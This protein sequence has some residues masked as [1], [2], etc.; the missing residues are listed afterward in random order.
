MSAGA[1][2]AVVDLAPLLLIADDAAFVRESYLRVLGR[3]C[4]IGGFVHY[5][6]LLRTRY[7]RRAILWQLMESAEAK[8]TGRRYVGLT[9]GSDTGG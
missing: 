7:P 2:V 9:M 4:D 3:E 5:R 8:A 6:E 1:A